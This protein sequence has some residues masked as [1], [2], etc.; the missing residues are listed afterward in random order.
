M[1]FDAARRRFYIKAGWPGL[2]NRRWRLRKGPSRGFEES[3]PDTASRSSQVAHK[4][5]PSVCL[6]VC[7]CVVSSGRV[8]PGCDVTTLYD[9]IDKYRCYP[10]GI[11][12]RESSQRPPV[13][14]TFVTPPPSHSLAQIQTRLR[15]FQSNPKPTILT[16]DEY[17][18]FISI[19]F[20]LKKLNKDSINNLRD[21]RTQSVASNKKM[22]I[23]RVVKLRTM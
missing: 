8:S 13:K 9:D 11:L 22:Y 2:K 1:T 6:S 14:T 3:C 12:I 18:V 17:M 10:T 21:Q 7:L 23:F 16:L 5:R 20:L 15:L 4:S 19:C